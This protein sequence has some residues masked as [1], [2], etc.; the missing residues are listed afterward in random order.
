LRPL[1]REGHRSQYCGPTDNPKHAE[2]FHDRSSISIIATY[3]DNAAHC[4]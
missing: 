3:G 4:A 1:K 2:P